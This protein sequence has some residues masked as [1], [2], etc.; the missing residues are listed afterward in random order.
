VLACWGSHT[1]FA[2]QGEREKARE[3]EKEG[4][5]ERERDVEFSRI[6]IFI[7]KRKDRCL[8]IFSY[9]VSL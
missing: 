9:L 3:R 6:V 1:L 2:G 5:R 8:G 4:G 7:Y